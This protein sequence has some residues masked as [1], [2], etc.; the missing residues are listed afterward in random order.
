MEKIDWNDVFYYDETSTSCL[1]W[2]ANRANNKV[3]KDDVAGSVDNASG[4]YRVGLHGKLYFCHRIIYEI[5][6]N[7]PLQAGESVDH[8][9]GRQ[10]DN[11]INNLRVVMHT[12]NMR[13][14]KMRIDN[15]SG[16]VGV[17]EIN[18]GCGNFYYVASWNNLQ[19]KLCQKCFSVTKLGLLPAFSKA[20]TYRK[21]MIAEL[22]KQGAGY[23]DRHGT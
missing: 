15:S 6:N 3:K 13:N 5:L 22:N 16:E 4:Y 8:M 1:R 10:S 21:K 12:Q 20:V 18:N 23:S 14:V 19:G 2:K 11:R 17:S 7:A 9:N